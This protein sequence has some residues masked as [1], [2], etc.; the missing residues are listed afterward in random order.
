MGIKILP[1]DINESGEKFTVE[2]DAVRFGLAAVKNVGGAAIQSI[3]KA[4]NEAR[5]KS[6]EDFYER[7]DSRAVNKRVMES[8]IRSGAMDSFNAPRKGMIEQLDRLLE[9]SIRK[10]ETSIKL[11]C[12]ILLRSV[13]SATVNYGTEDFDPQEKLAHEKEALGFYILRT[14][15]T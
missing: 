13:K 9:D 8:L 6:L 11:H 2:H 10:K 15:I 12:L 4:R 1:P 14:S 3:A 7:V 5:F